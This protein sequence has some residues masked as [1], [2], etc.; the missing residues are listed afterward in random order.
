MKSTHPKILLAAC[1]F[2][3]VVY[4]LEGCPCV[5]KCAELDFPMYL[6]EGSERCWRVYY[7]DMNIE[8]AREECGRDGGELASYSNFVANSNQLTSRDVWVNASYTEGIGWTWDGTAATIIPDSLWAVASPPTSGCA[9]LSHSGTDL[10]LNPYPCANQLAFLCT[11]KRVLFTPVTHKVSVASVQ[12]VTGVQLTMQ[13]TNLDVDMQFALSTTDCSTT[14]TGTAPSA[15]TS[16]SAVWAINIALSPA[17][18]YVLCWGHSGVFTVTNVAVR[19]AGLPLL[20]NANLGIQVGLLGTDVNITGTHLTDDLWV[21]PF[22]SQDCS[23]AAATPSSRLHPS[24]MENT[25]A[26]FVSPVGLPAD[27]NTRT[28]CVA[29]SILSPLASAFTPTAASITA[30][31]APTIDPFAFS[32]TYA[33]SH[34]S[35][36]VLTVT[37]S[38]MD[39]KGWSVVLF[40]QGGCSGTPAADAILMTGCAANSCTFSLGAVTPV[41]KV[42][43]AC[44]LMSDKYSTTGVTVL[45]T[46]A[47]EFSNVLVEKSF[48][49]AEGDGNIEIDIVARNLETSGSSD[50]ML[51]LVYV[52]SGE[53]CDAPTGIVGVFSSVSPINGTAVMPSGLA[54]SI[55]VCVV[56][57]LLKPASSGDW[58]A[59]FSTNIRMQIMHAP[60][61]TPGPVRIIPY[62]QKLSTETIIVT[63]ANF[64]TRHLW[65]AFSFDSSCSQIEGN[66]LTMP[67]TTG[68]Q[69]H[70]TSAQIFDLADSSS[71]QPT[72][73]HLCYASFVTEPSSWN[74]TDISFKALPAPTIDSAAK[75]YLLTSQEAKDGGLLLNVRGSYLQEGV[76]WGAFIAGDRSVGDLAGASCL[77]VRIAC[78]EVGSGW[79][80]A[81]TVTAPP[82][83]VE[84]TTYLVVWVTSLMEPSVVPDNGVFSGYRIQTLTPP[85]FHQKQHD[86][87][88]GEWNVGFDLNITGTNIGEGVW[89]W[90]QPTAKSCN[91]TGADTIALSGD[92]SGVMTTLSLSPETTIFSQDKN[93]KLCYTTSLTSDVNADTTIS[94]TLSEP[95]VF[96]FATLS[97]TLAQLWDSQVQFKATLQG[98]NLN[99]GDIWT[100]LCRA[101]CSACTAPT[102]LENSMLVVPGAQSPTVDPSV[103]A[104]MCW[105]ATAGSAPESG[106]IA[107]SVRVIFPSPFVTAEVTEVYPMLQTAVKITPSVADAPL[108]ANTWASLCDGAWYSV[109]A[110]GTFVP[111]RPDSNVVKQV[112]LTYTVSSPTTASTS[113]PTNIKVSWAGTPVL[114]SEKVNIPLAALGSGQIS[115]SL[116]GDNL[117]PAVYFKDMPGTAQCS[118]VTSGGVLLGG[119]SSYLLQI[120]FEGG[121]PEEVRLCWAPQDAGVERP[122]WSEGGDLGVVAV[123]QQKPVFN[124]VVQRKSVSDMLEGRVEVALQGVNLVPP[125]YI[126]LQSGAADCN[127]QGRTAVVPLNILSRTSAY[128][129][130]PSTFLEDPPLNGLVGLCWLTQNNPS[131]QGM[132]MPVTVQVAGMPTVLSSTP[133]TPLMTLLSG[134]TEVSVVGSNLQEDTGLWVGCDRTMPPS[135]VAGTP[136][137][138]STTVPP[139]VASLGEANVPLCVAISP[140]G[141][142]KNITALEEIE[143]WSLEIRN[144]PQVNAFQR[145]ANAGTLID[146]TGTLLAA[147]T[148]SPGTLHVFRSSSTPCPAAIV[149]DAV[150]ATSNTVK[151]PVPAEP[152]GTVLKLCMA[153]QSQSTFYEQAVVITVGIVT[154][155]PDTNPPDTPAPDTAEPTQAPDTPAP[156]TPAPD[157]P[158]PAVECLQPDSMANMIRNTCYLGGL[159]DCMKTN[160]P[161]EC[162]NK[163]VECYKKTEGV[164]GD[165]YQDMGAGAKET[166][167]FAMEMNN[168]DANVFAAAVSASVLV[169]PEAVR[170]VSVWPGSTHVSFTLPNDTSVYDELVATKQAG[171]PY[172]TALGSQWTPLSIATAVPTST[173]VTTVPGTETP[174]SSSSTNYLIIFLAVG[175]AVVVVLLGI[176]LVFWVKRNKEQSG[177]EQE[178]EFDSIGEEAPQGEERPSGPCGKPVEACKCSTGECKC[179]HC[180]LAESRTGSGRVTQVA[181]I[182]W[183]DE[184]EEG[185]E[186]EMDSPVESGGYSVHPSR[187]SAV[188][189]RGSTSTRARRRDW[190][191]SCSPNHNEIESHTTYTPTTGV[192]RTWMVPASDISTPRRNPLPPRSYQRSASP[193]CTTCGNIWE[194][195]RFCG[196]CGMEQDTYYSP[197]ESASTFDQPP[198]P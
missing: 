191:S 90:F 77:A 196:Y 96:D 15:S 134:G 110:V 4:G 175:A 81:A 116:A 157:T 186:G 22:N 11:K 45:V 63:G 115:L 167:S 100:A 136:G 148:S 98:A 58:S 172:F 129:N 17:T 50:P 156:D 128:V 158:T 121:Y 27:G 195:G 108:P 154:P 183:S 131:E 43:Y 44:M 161:V 94:L 34:T 125:L 1:C 142:T 153:L 91:A 193:L 146:V 173:P 67:A 78:T 198:I 19:V 13:G 185:D 5:S 31:P 155:A 14:T 182:T 69:L 151:V 184:E 176:L 102:L 16:T 33:Q 57:S 74:A 168:F 120:D 12:T 46:P 174:S 107:S 49:R 52:P 192:A 127:P 48:S 144:M 70:F 51:Y 35:V 140:T 42:L 97:L 188:V 64:A 84:G 169:P 122:K 75:E 41:G 101:D 99:Q 25:E 54:G 163:Y 60:E 53:A 72:S 86:I 133:T 85:S 106:F 21:A 88:V 160:T 61:F 137:N 135:R 118:D 119:G 82:L 10:K 123:L 26:W 30:I 71:G 18:E 109:S 73:V 56:A 7:D 166:L 23:G 93:I 103:G 39:Q 28:L 197:A 65:V 112:C 47:P 179:N 40:Y 159:L 20:D 138:Y 55:T 111:T 24:G 117:S 162:G 180:M 87:S 3:P 95:P 194:G 177:T 139:Q 178:K 170:V 105:V 79:C 8:G 114:T 113:F 143:G 132:Q 124:S 68:E 165:C 189:S 36:K 126:S 6:A 145:R 62:S 141:T 89:V 150:V 130:L 190:M 187:P 164:H 2:L 66:A 147:S 152:R 83:A 181:T 149:Q 80:S 59:A 29:T 171:N 92:K 104:T 32:I 38:N 76:L 37:G 9:F